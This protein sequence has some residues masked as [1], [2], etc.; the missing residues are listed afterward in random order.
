MGRLLFYFRYAGRSLWRSGHWTA[1]AIF[2]VAA[3]VATVVALRSLGL[4]I[5]DSLLSNVRQFNHGDIN[6]SHVANYGPFSFAV[7]RGQGGD[8]YTPDDVARIEA[9]A[10]SRGARITAYMTASNIQITPIQGQQFGRP[11][12]TS[13][14]F[15]DPQTYAL[16]S[17]I[18]ALDPPGVPLRDLF[19][20]G[21]EVVISQNMADLNGLKVGDTVYVS[22]SDQ[23]FTV[24]GIVPTETEA[25]VN[26]I[27]AAFFGFAYFDL[28]QAETLGLLPLPNT[29]GI[30]LPDGATVAEIE[31]AW[32]ELRDVTDYREINTAPWIIQRNQELSDMVGRFIVAMGL[33]ALLI[34]GVGIMNTMLVLVGRRALEIAALKTFGLKGRQVAALFTAEAVVLGIVGSLVGIIVGLLLSRV[35]NAYGE[36][37]LQQKLPWRIHPEAVMYGLALGLVVTLVF[38]VLPVLTATRVRPGLILRPNDNSIPRASLLQTLIALLGIVLVLGYVAG[39]ILG[40]AV[41]SVAG[42]RAP[43]PTLLGIAGVAGALLFLALLVGVLWWVVWLVSHLPAFGKVELR[44]ALRNL[45]TRRLRTSITLLALTAGMFALSSITFF[46]LGAREIV[47][48]QFSETLGGNVLLLPLLPRSIVEPLINAQLSQAG[49]VQSVTHLNFNTARVVAI[50]ARPVQIEGRLAGLPLITLVRDTTNP[51]LT[52]GPVLAGRDLLPDDRGRNVVVLSEQSALEAMVSL[53][54]VGNDGP[55]TL[56]DFGIEV[57]STVTLRTRLGTYDYEVVGIV[58]NAN[59]FAP[60]VAGAYLPPDAPGIPTERDV[61]VLQVAPD[62]INEVLLALSRAPLVFALDVAFID[63][64]MKRLIDQLSA[65]PTVVGLLSLLAAAVIMANT[66]SLATLERRR[67]IGILKA[68]GLKRRRVLWVMLLENTFIG[69]LGGLLGVGLSAAGVSLM[70][71]LGM[72]LTIPIPREA[73]PIALAL[74][75]A[76]VL[77]A[78]LATFLSARVAVRERVAAVLRY[79]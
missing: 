42:S 66:V 23:T 56:K 39:Q 75:A 4:A 67:Q 2:C 21:R 64:L 55:V 78:W 3:G 72:G 47:R 20:G 74:L 30:A 41:V 48:F 9:W 25:S 61:M 50:N 49:G 13:T 38:G 54:N 5:N 16:I 27:F 52:S 12:F 7:Q 70:T 77:I 71:T 62:K 53:R 65:I 69:L 60:N 34:G 6:I 8:T 17:E 36:A 37:F 14:F 79:E 57:G 73:V 58:G 59:G 19:Q 18:R 26:N 68:V 63:S 45:T 40:P 29:V 46:G 33:G 24:R 76:S 10:A 31:Q 44:L 15:I 32:W 51:A 28:R 43:N 11:Q 35:V 1:F 22:G